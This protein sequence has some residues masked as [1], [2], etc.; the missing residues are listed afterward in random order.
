MTAEQL[1]IPTP[2]RRI[3]R[4]PPG[5]REDDLL[6]SVRDLAQLNGWR[7]FHC[8]DSRKSIGP[9][10]P[11]AVLVS[12]R[13]RRVV[14]AEL[15]RPDGTT[16]PEQDQ[17]LAELGAAGQEVALWRPADLP[18]IAIVLRGRRIE[19]GEFGVTATAPRAQRRLP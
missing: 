16:T 6:N 19:P 9:G 11:G 13:Q 5:L 17:W 18:A 3:R 10:F 12:A 7:M 15:K 8:Y 4:T 1:A 14:Y 2:G